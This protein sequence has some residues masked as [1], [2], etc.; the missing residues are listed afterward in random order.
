MADPITMLAMAGNKVQQ[1]ANGIGNMLFTTWR[2]RKNHQR[3]Q[4]LQNNQFGNQ[5]KLNQQQFSNQMQLNQQGFDLQKRMWNETNAEAQM[6]HYKD[7][8]LNPALMYGQS[9]ATGTTGSVSSGSASGGSA[10]GGGGSQMSNYQGIQAQMAQAQMALMNAQTNKTNQ[11]AK[12]IGEGG[13]DYDNTKAETL[14]KETQAALNKVM[15]ESKNQDIAESMQRIENLSSQN[16]LTEEQTRLAKQ[17][18]AVNRVKMDLDKA[19]IKLTEQKT[20][21]SMEGVKAMWRKFG[22]DR[23]DVKTRKNQANVQKFTA[24][25]KTKYPSLWSVFGK[26]INDGSRIGQ[27]GEQTLDNLMWWFGMGRED[28]EKVEFE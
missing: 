28:R 27:E 25:M 16:K 1:K 7:A 19:G 14:N 20:K 4:D 26:L 22:L 18:N 24:E 11:E 9:G 3:N 17:Q 5:G 2:D 15:A 21:E 6:K 23:E 13:V 12:N 10:A 8:G